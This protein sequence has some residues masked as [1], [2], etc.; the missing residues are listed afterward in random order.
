MTGT[1][2]K[3]TGLRLLR[4]PDVLAK[5]NLSKPTLYRMLE[6]GEFPKPTLI[7]NVSLWQEDEVDAWI[8]AQV[9]ASRA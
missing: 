8:R 2:K 9:A 3:P 6:A 5:I 7:R 1:A 4:V